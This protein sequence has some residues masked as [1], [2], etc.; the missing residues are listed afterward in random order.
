MPI[1][2]K[3]FSRP[4]SIGLHIVLEDLVPGVVGR[5]SAAAMQVFQRFD[6]QIGIHGARAVAQQQREVHHLARLARFDDQR[7]LIAR[8]LADQMVVH[9]RK[10]QQAGNR[11]VLFVHAAVGENQQ[12]V[13]GLDRQRG[14]PAERSR[15]PVRAASRRLPR[16]RASA[17]W[18][19]EN[20]PSSR[21]AVFPG[22]S[23][24]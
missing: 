9:G 3:V 7:H 18:W 6:R 4:L 17:A 11:R 5:E 21:G 14:A 20:R 15:R 13:A 10:R 23:W 16:G 2:E 19:P 12:R 22:A 1:F 8:L 24:R